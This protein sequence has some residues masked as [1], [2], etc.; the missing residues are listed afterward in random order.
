MTA[1]WA[2]ALATRF[3]HFILTTNLRASPPSHLPLSSLHATSSN[4]KHHV[5]TTDEPLPG[6]HRAVDA[7]VSWLACQASAAA[8]M[9]TFD[10]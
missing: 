3:L 9:V 6:N 5:V 7:S 1:L 4:E 8:A 2:S 10:K